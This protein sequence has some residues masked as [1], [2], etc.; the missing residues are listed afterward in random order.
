MLKKLFIS[1]FLFSAFFL[2][3]VASVGAT[4]AD[5]VGLS[6]GSAIILVDAPLQDR[7]IGSI[8]SPIYGTRLSCAGNGRAEL[9]EVIGDGN[10]IVTMSTGE[11]VLS[12]S[13]RLYEG[14]TLQGQGAT[15]TTIYNP[16]TYGQ[17]A[18]IADFSSG[19]KFGV[20]LRDLQVRGNENSGDGLYAKYA[21][22]LQVDRCWFTENGG[23]G[24]DLRDCYEV[25]ISDTRVDY[26]EG[27]GVNYQNCHAFY[28]TGG[29]VDYNGSQGIRV[30][31][32]SSG[33]IQ[34]TSLEKNGSSNLYIVNSKVIKAES[35]YIDG[36][37]Q[38]VNAVH[39][40]SSI[41]CEVSNSLI[42]NCLAGIK[43][44]GDSIGNV[45]RTNY[46]NNNIHDFQFFKVSGCNRFYDNRFQGKISGNSSKQ[47]F[48]NNW[49]PE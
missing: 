40:Y 47:I 43:L 28:H 29:R 41:S 2:F 13:I 21:H 7:I 37:S 12:A 22:M 11:L 23:M 20:Q 33:N 46:L 9:Q 32:V 45:F 31:G 34:R 10:K 27:I 15:A 6:E 3:P 8:L 39:I 18:L 16:L 48:L 44:E 36:D 26:N 1:A 24:L 4:W 49:E 19:S 42:F 38:S 14:T 17:P 25:H 30:L 5:S 35:L